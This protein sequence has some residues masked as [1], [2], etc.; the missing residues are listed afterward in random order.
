MPSVMALVSS[1]LSS[2]FADL[3][4]E[5][6]TVYVENFRQEKISPISPPAPSNFITLIF[7][8]VLKM[9]I[10]IMVTFTILAKKF[11]ANFFS[12]S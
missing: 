5:Q 8:L 1:E 10:I 2:A 6:V 11:S 4:G 3:K 7:C 9:I 12:G